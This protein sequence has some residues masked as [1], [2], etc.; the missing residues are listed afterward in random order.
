[1]THGPENKPGSVGEYL[2]YLLAPHEFSPES[3]PPWPPD[4]F[5]VTATVL[6]QTGGYVRVAQQEELGIDEGLPHRW[7]HSV[8]EIARSWRSSIETTLGEAGSVAEAVD[9][10]PVPGEVASWWRDLA[11]Q[12]PDVMPSEVMGEGERGRAMCRNLLRLALVADEASGGAGWPAET[13]EV[14]EFQTEILEL[15]ATRPHLES[16]CSWIRTE[17]ARVLPKAHTPQRGLELSADGRSDGKKAYIPTFAGF[18]PLNTGTA[19]SISRD[20]SVSLED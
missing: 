8:A 2:A 18:Y 19:S 7:K 11:R 14:S 20:E 5:A 12:A 10:I 6:Q 3:C 13:G 1:M 15:L 16:L 17:K 4:V 9:A